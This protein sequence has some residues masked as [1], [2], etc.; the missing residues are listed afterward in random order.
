MQTSVS[1]SGLGTVEGAELGGWEGNLG[2]NQPCSQ[3]EQGVSGVA[4]SWTR[5]SN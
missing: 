4:K 5:L 3:G 2:C 1:V